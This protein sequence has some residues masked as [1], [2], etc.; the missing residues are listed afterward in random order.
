M[1]SRILSGEKSSVNPAALYNS[2]MCAF[3]QGLMHWYSFEWH[4][5]VF[6]ELLPIQEHQFGN[7]IFD[8]IKDFKDVV[9]AA[10]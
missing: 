9:V 6:P 4:F 8:I 5:L 7:A 3:L 10:S 2:G 1:S